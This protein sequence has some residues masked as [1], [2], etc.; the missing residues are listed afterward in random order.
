MAS[1]Q[2]LVGRDEDGVAHVVCLQRLVDRRPGE[3]GVGAECDALSLGL[4]A[5][6]LGHEQFLPVVRAG[7]VPWVQLRDEAVAVV[8]EQKQRVVAHR[9]EVPVV[10]TAVLLTMH[11]A[12]AGIQVEHRAVGSVPRLAMSDHIAVHGHQPDEVLLASQQLGLEPMQRGGQGRT[13]VPSL[14]RSS[15]P[16]PSSKRARPSRRSPARRDACVRPRIV[17]LAVRHPT[18]WPLIGARKNRT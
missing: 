10:G 15:R 11:R 12:L 14:R 17:V 7:D 4:L 16:T 1:S 2:I 9:L 3:G 13:P 18:F 6:D 8:V 5:V